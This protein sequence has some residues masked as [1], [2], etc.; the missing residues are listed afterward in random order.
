MPL[1]STGKAAGKQNRFR[2]A[3]PSQEKTKHPPGWWRTSFPVECCV[4]SHRAC[5]CAFLPR[6]QPFVAPYFQATPRGAVFPAI[7]KV[8]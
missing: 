8:G 4:L 1:P 2:G 6:A 5:R 7:M 3:S